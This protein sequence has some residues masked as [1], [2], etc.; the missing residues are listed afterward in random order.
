MANIFDQRQERKEE[1]F[2]PA[3][4]NRPV[5]AQAGTLGKVVWYGSFIFLIPIISHVST[6]NSL[7]EQQNAIQEA[8]SGIDIQLTKRFDTLSKLYQ[9]VKGYKEM[10]QSVF[11]E[12][13]R[14]RNLTNSGNTAANS[15]EIESL[16]QNI[17]SRLIA[18]VENYPDLKASKLFQELMDETINIE[19]EIAASRRLYNSKV[20]RFNSQLFT[21][22]SAV[23][24]DSLGLETIPLYSA[25]KT[26]I[27]DV[28][29]NF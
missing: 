25:S 26:Q 29:M 24:A 1:S 23:I 19:R 22:P 4:D 20:N 5:K 13:S 21:W 6:R 7:L 10:E 12:I 3:V 18:V 14:L 11:E 16:N 9:Q 8:A 28:Q 2:T 17:F 27:Q 15:A